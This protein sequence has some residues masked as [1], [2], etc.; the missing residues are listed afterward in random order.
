MSQRPRILLIDDDPLI[1]RI[2]VKTLVAAGY[3]TLEAA[4]GTEGL[5]L[6]ESS[7]PDLI[8]L[9]VMMP[10]VDGFEVCARCRSLEA[11]SRIPI[12]MLTALDQS[13]AQVRGLEIGADDYI[14]KPF[15]LD[16][17]ESRAHV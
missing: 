9:D 15:N 14:T 3:E 17:L 5:K 7:I 8:L 16:V 11:T 12:I 6:A 1:R 10:G 4:N 2:I 13:E